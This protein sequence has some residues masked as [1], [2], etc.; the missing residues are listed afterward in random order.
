VDN[1]LV[2]IGTFALLSG[3]S[4]P[5]LRN[6]DELGL[7]KPADVDTRT[8]Y[9]RYQRSQLERAR[10]IRA[11][12]RIELPLEDVRRVLEGDDLEIRSGLGAHRARLAE[13]S[14]AFDQMVEIVE[15]YLKEGIAMQTEAAGVRFAALNLGVKS[16]AELDT[17]REFWGSLLGAELED[18]GLGSK[19]MRVGRDEQFFMFNIRVRSED[20]PHYGHAAAFGLSV[21][22]LDDFHRRA[23]AAGAKEHYSPTDSDVMPRHS[24]FEDPVGNRVVVFQQ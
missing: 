14:R 1:D 15:T 11:L 23:L 24:R 19:Q 16:Q 9:R 12:R 17:A 22:D 5:M 13:R 2:T 10:T 3:L 18:W 20:E 7:L 21:D 6:Y 8:G 4:V